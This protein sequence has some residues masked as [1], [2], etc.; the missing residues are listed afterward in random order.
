[1]ESLQVRPNFLHHNVEQI[2][3]HTYYYTVRKRA[4]L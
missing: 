3:L 4:M 1:M 2:R